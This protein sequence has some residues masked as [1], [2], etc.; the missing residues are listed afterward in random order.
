MYGA[1]GTEQVEHGWTGILRLDRDGCGI[2]IIS[3]RC[4]RFI[5][6]DDSMGERTSD[7][8][9]IS[10]EHEITIFE[11]YLYRYEQPGDERREALIKA[12]LSGQ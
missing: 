11:Q 10:P 12:G 7:C 4:L 3:T 5:R 1:C 8:R 9:Q 2:A 6:N